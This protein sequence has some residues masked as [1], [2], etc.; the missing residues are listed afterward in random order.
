MCRCIKRNVVGIFR[1]YL[2]PGVVDIPFVVPQ[3]DV[4][5]GSLRVNGDWVDDMY[6]P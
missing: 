4:E 2:R 1:F 3:V 6:S 5:D